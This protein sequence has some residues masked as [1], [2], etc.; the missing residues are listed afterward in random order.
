[1]LVEKRKERKEG[2]ISAVFLAVLVLYPLRHM[3]HGVDLMDTGYNYANFTYIENMDSMW[4]FSTYLANLAGKLL[5]KLPFG[6]TY[7]GLNLYTGLSISVLAAGAFLFCVKRVRMPRW[8]AFAGT[9]LA[10]CLSWC[11]TAL[12]Y[13]YLTYLL[14]AAAVYLL[15]LALERESRYTAGCFIL[16]GICLG[17]NIFVRFSNLAQAA[18]ILAVWAMACIRR[19]KWKKTLSQTLLCLGG[20]LLG[21]LLGLALVSITDGAGAYVGGILR[22]LS[23]PSEASDYTIY[24]ML[25]GQIHYY[26]ISLRWLVLLL[27][28]AGAGLLCFR[29]LPQRMHR[30]L[31]VIYVCG[32]I[33][34][35]YGFYKAGM[36]SLDYYNLYSVFQWAALLLLATHLV[37]VA[38]IFGRQ[39]TEQEKLLCGMNMLVVLLTPLGSNNHLFSAINNIFLAA[40]MTLWMLWRFAKWLPEKAGFSMRPIRL[41]LGAVVCFLGWQS[42]LCSSH[43][44][45]TETTGGG[46]RS[47]YVE[48]NR[49]LRGVKTDPERAGQL[50]ELS[51]FV[52][53]KGLK[54]REVLLYGDIPAMSFYLEMPFVLTPWPDLR[55]YNLTVMKEALQ[56]LEQQISQ[57][58]RECPVLLL[59]RKVRLYETEEEKVLLLQEWIEKYGYQI[60]FENEE[61][62]LLLAAD[63]MEDYYD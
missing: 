31:T 17:L 33:A 1:M 10:V 28:A 27:A 24:S 12:L 62:M 14:F 20:Y 38:V 22:L 43:Y 48:D 42:L 25:Y 34:L 18:M 63:G 55:S 49:V 56:D 5:T 52:E 37:G 57:K 58:D 60:S 13:N 19:Q 16:A 53:E 8:I 40:P 23:M 36:Y 61:F 21:V 6:D 39:F 35:F 46:E 9:F 51:Q 32:M 30:V 26:I 3:F 29:L 45:F 47:A 4:Y 50:T 41:M 2:L 15:Y 11:P 59:S 54:G 44:V 7:A